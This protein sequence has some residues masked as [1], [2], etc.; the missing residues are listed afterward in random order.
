MTA[1][2]VESWKDHSIL[3]HQFRGVIDDRDLA[4]TPQEVIERVKCELVSSIVNR[5][6]LELGPRIDNAIKDAWKDRSDEVAGRELPCAYCKPPMFKGWS[7]GK[8]PYCGKPRTK[9]AQ[10][11][12]ISHDQL[13]KSPPVHA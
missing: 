6:M 10:N 2:H 9:T 8:C 12:Q 13:S 4:M 11:H 5:I 1:S 3:G 7:D